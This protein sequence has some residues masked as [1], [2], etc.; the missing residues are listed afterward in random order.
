M[1]K[2]LVEWSQNARGDVVI[3]A[4]SVDDAESRVRAGAYLMA[5][6]IREDFECQAT[7]IK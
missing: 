4:D 3:I 7:A 5:P 2:Y 6:P 1:P